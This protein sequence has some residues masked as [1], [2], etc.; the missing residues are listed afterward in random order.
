MELTRLRSKELGAWNFALRGTTPQVALRAAT[1][2]DA[3]A[4]WRVVWRFIVKFRA[5]S[6]PIRAAAH[7]HGGHPKILIPIHDDFQNSA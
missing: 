7:F 1:P 6:E 3:A 2:Q 5:G 4:S